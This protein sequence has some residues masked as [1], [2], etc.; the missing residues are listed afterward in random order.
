MEYIIEKNGKRR[1]A[2][3]VICKQCG[4]SFLVRKNWD[5]K[6][7]SHECAGLFRRTRVKLTCHTC[8]KD[9]ERS[10]ERLKRS[11]S[12]LYFCCRNCKDWA[13]TLEAGCSEIQPN[14][15]GSTKKANCHNLLK[16]QD[17][18]CCDCGEDRKYLLAVHH[19]DSNPLN[20]E[21]SNLEVVCGNCHKK[22]HLFK[23][24]GEWIYWTKALTD[25]TLLKFL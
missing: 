23:K 2:K 20:N 16:E 21:F 4:K 22:R 15:F 6:C 13:Q 7:C 3:R 25:R 14:H 10:K 17:T 5:T 19:K 8:G 18:K 24:N 1:E 9:F 11:K 12:G